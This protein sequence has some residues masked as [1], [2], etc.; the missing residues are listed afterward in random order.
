MATA[1]AAVRRAIPARGAI[2]RARGLAPPLAAATYSEVYIAVR[3]CVGG[4]LMALVEESDWN[5][6]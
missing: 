2:S 5:L 1:A 6:F 4:E 3:S